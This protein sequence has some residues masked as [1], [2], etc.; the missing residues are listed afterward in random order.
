MRLDNIKSE[1]KYS[2]RFEEIKNFI[3]AE[4]RELCG[5][6]IP[7]NFKIVEKYI[8]ISIIISKKDTLKS[9]CE[10]NELGFI[11]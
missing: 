5:R 8:P 7:T 11:R 3:P 1:R 4:F 2:I 9:I 10:K 6:Y